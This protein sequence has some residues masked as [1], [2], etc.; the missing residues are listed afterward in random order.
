M[1]NVTDDFGRVAHLLLAIPAI[2][3][4]YLTL[5]LTAKVTPTKGKTAAGTESGVEPSGRTADSDPGS[6]R[7]R[8]ADDEQPRQP[9]EDLV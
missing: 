2:H 4:S 1:G 6:A 8:T 3:K 7:R 5:T 9:V